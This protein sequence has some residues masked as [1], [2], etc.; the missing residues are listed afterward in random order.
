MTTTT[1]QKLFPIPIT[2]HQSDEDEYKKIY[3]EIENRALTQSHFRSA[4]KYA[5]NSPE[6]GT[7][8][9]IKEGV[10]PNAGSNVIKEFKLFYTEQFLF[11]CLE[12]Y[13]DKVGDNPEKANYLD[14]VRSWMVRY[15]GDKSH[16]MAHQ[17][18]HSYLSFVYYHHIDQ[19]EG[20]EIVFHAPNHCLPWFFSS[21]AESQFIKPCSGMVVI[22]P[23]F[24]VH[25]VNS[26]HQ[27]EE[28]KLRISLAGEIRISPEFYAKTV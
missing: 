27:Q 1:V 5:G 28:N 10:T 25:S 2:L 26:F 13:L 24:L 15:S 14:I 3:S 19:V 20:G 12:S 17:H 21:L 18:A 8:E 23:S 6:F 4:E 9:L 22:F 16:L 11:K 7:S